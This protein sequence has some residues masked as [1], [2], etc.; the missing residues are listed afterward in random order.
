MAGNRHINL[1]KAD[2]LYSSCN[3]IV[4]KPSKTVSSNNWFNYAIKGVVQFARLT[5]TD[6]WE[7]SV[8]LSVTDEKAVLLF[9]SFSILC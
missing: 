1:T 7:Q 5:L 6:Q 4:F 8:G 3:P 2:S 9:Q